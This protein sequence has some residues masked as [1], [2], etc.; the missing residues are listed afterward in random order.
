MLRMFGFAVVR[1]DGAPAER[2]RIAA[3]ALIASIPVIATSVWF[4]SLES[5]FWHPERQL[6]PFGIGI[7]LMIWFVWLAAFT[8]G[9]GP[10][11]RIT[12]TWIVPR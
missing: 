7:I 11:E 5:W 6:W 2:W 10:G 9:R 8:S 1:S 12:G 4:L 3:R